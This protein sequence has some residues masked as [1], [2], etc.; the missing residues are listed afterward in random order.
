MMQLTIDLP[1][2]GTAGVLE[3][4]RRAKIIMPRVEMISF[5]NDLLELQVAG[6]ISQIIL[7][8]ENESEGDLDMVHETIEEAVISGALI[9]T[10]K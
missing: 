4:I 3:T 9:S 5:A 1:V 8:L 7:W 2:L 6:T 10:R